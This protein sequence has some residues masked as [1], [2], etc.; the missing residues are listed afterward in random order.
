MK[1]VVEK[2]SFMFWY[3]VLLPEPFGPA[4]ILILGICATNEL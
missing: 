3:N 1:M 4:K 2:Y